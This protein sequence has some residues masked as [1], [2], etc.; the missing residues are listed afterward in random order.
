[1]YDPV[2]CPTCHT[3]SYANLK[4]EYTLKDSGT[5]FDRDYDDWYEVGWCRLYECPKCRE[6]IVELLDERNETGVAFQG[7]VWPLPQVTELVWD[8]AL[9]LLVRADLREADRS[10]HAKLYNAFGAMAR[11]VVHSI[12]ADKGAY[13]NKDLHNQIEDV[14]RRNLV[15]AEV[16]QRMQVLRTLGRNGAHPEWENVSQEQAE[17]G[18]ELLLWIVREVYRVGVPELPAWQHKKRYQLPKKP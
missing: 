18:M 6:P 4:G 11:R 1:V 9:P 12:C 2:E 17:K 3:E 16:A 14:L 7:V 10:Y 13:E 8:T 5:E 15:S